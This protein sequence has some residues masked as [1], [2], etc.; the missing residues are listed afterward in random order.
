VV[1]VPARTLD[2]H[3]CSPGAPG[4]QVRSSG[5]YV[6]R[7]V[8]ELT[9]IEA[10]DIFAPWRVPGLLDTTGYCPPVVEVNVSPENRGPRPSA[11]AP[12]RPGVSLE[13]GP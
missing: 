11:L 1:A 2:M 13:S 5:D 10:P 7:Y 3:E 8:E 12:G 6:R 9:E 4:A